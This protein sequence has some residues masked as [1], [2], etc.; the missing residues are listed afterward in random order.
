MVGVSPEE[1]AADPAALFELIL[2]EDL[3]RVVAAEDATVAALG[4]FD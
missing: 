1:V 3:P 2:P 4:P